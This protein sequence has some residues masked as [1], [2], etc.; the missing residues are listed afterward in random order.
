[1]PK[2]SSN[3]PATFNRLDTQL[4]RPHRMHAQTYFSDIFVH[5]RAMNGRSDLTNHIDHLEAVLECMRRII[6][7]PTQL[8][9]SLM[10]NRFT[11]LC[12]SLGSEVFERFLLRKKTELIG[13]FLR[14]RRTYVSGLALP[15][16][17]TST[18]RI[19]QIWLGHYPILLKRM[20]SGVKLTPSIKLLQR[21]KRVSFMRQSWLCLILIG[22]SVSFVTHLTLP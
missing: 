19:T 6:M 22:L 1:M 20:W 18:V 2:R 12:T 9:A 10:Q 3:F 13:R 7:M 8:S 16:T 15:I 5:S 21:L 17:S 4:F 14:T 11:F